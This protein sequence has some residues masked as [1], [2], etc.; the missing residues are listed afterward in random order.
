MSEFGARSA[1]LEDLGVHILTCTGDDTRRDGYGLVLG[2]KQA[3]AAHQRREISYRTLR[4]LEGR[5]LAGA[6]T[7]GRCLG[8]AG[9]AVIEPQASIV[10]TIFELYAQGASFAS[11]ATQLNSTSI[12]APRGG[13]WRASSI[14]AI[15]ANPR[16]RGEVIYGQTT[17]RGSAAD[18]A[19]KRRAERAG[20]P[21][22]ARTDESQR[23]VPEELWRAAQIRRVA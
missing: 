18:S 6:S 1:E 12:K 9:T 20:G 2:I 4:G 15:L 11:V 8:Y 3:I 22:V 16:Y 19:R 5:A 17:Y 10:R 13:A 23:I 21:L 14:D 7:G